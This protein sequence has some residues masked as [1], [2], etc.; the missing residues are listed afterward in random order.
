ML[1]YSANKKPKDSQDHDY[2]TTQSN[3]RKMPLPHY[4]ERY[5]PSPKMNRRHFKSSLKNTFKKA[6]YDHPK[7]LMPPL[8]SSSKRKTDGYDQYKTIDA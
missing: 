2:G 4:Q 7:A 1:M 6:I 5:T 8:S 3:L